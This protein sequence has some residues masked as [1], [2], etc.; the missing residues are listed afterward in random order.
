MIRFFLKK[1]LLQTKP[2]LGWSTRNFARKAKNEKG[3]L[4]KPLEEF[5]QDDENQIVK[6]N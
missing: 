3:S 4:L 6:T 2:Y 1:S 5:G